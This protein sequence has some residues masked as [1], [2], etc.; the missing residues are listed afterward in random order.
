MKEI[1]INYEKE[2]KNEDNVDIYTDGNLPEVIVGDVNGSHCF[3]SRVTYE[4]RK[5]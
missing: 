4:E 1:L 5:D 2:I 3:S